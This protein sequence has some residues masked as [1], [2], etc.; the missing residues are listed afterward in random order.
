[1]CDLVLERVRRILA[2]AVKHHAKFL[3]LGAW[4]CGA[5]G[6]R[7]SGLLVSSLTGGQ[8]DLPH[9]LDS[10]LIKLVSVVGV[11]DREIL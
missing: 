6:T 5:Y 3:I 10:T 7:T 4:G 1:L 8:Q 2:V 11:C 9:L